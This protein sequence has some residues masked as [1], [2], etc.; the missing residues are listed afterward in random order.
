VAVPIVVLNACRSAMLD[1]DAESAFASIAAALLQSGTRNAVAMGYN[2]Y[3]SAAEVL[4]PPFYRCLF[5]SGSVPEAVRA[6]R[7]ALEAKRERV[8]VRGRFPLADWLVPLL[9]QHEDVSLA[10]AT[11]GPAAEAPPSGPPVFGLEQETPLRSFMGRDGA[12]TSAGHGVPWQ[13][14]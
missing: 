9:Y 2:L 6:G 11:E 5:E 3:I 14:G 1:P 4:F 13:W 10:F 7:Q 12:S 8:C